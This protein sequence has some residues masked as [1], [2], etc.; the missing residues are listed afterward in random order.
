MFVLR[1]THGQHYHSLSPLSVCSGLSPWAEPERTRPVPL[2]R[3]PALAGRLL[4]ILKSIPSVKTRQMILVSLFASAIVVSGTLDGQPDTQ[5][6]IA[7]FHTA[8][9]RLR[10]MNNESSQTLVAIFRYIRQA[11]FSTRTVL[12]GNQSTPHSSRPLE[13]CVASTSLINAAAINGPTPGIVNR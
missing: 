5:T 1:F 9:Y 12:A 8:H 11:L 4:C 3:L 2:L 7:L 6:V 13:N 10:T